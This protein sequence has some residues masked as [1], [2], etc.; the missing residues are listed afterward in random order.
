MSGQRNVYLKEDLKAP[1]GEWVTSV[2]HAESG[3]RVQR[4]T[5]AWQRWRGIQNR[6]NPGG[7]VQRKRPTYVG[8]ANGFSDFQDFA[9]WCQSEPG[10]FDVDDSGRQ[11]E[12]DK[13]LI[14][15]GNKIYS[16]ETCCFVPGRV[17]RLIVF[18]SNRN[19]PDLPIGCSFHK[20]TKQYYSYINGPDGKSVH[21]GH[22]RNPLDAH[23]AWQFAKAAAIRAA[24][25]NMPDHL[26]RAAIAV[27]RIAESI[28]LDIENMKE[29]V[30]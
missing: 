29:S 27:L 13:D 8:C 10:H 20:H 24:V 16:R 12:L 28:E 1:N 3:V 11:F 5:L 19:R 4:H 17:N 30:F 25:V 9:D 21:L 26:S 7:N 15:P 6:C 14:S 23:R 22:Y 18:P 2:T